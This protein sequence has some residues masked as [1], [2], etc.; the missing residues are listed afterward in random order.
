L[1]GTTRFA[2]ASIANSPG[3]VEVGELH[4]ARTAFDRARD[5][6]AQEIGR[7]PEHRRHRA[8]RLRRSTVHRQPALVHQRERGLERQRAGERERAELAE[9]VS[10]AHDGIER[11][12]DRFR[13]R[14]VRD[15]DRGLRVARL[16]E[17]L[18]RAVLAHRAQ[19]VPENRLRRGERLRGRGIRAR[20]VDAHRDDLRTLPGKDHA[21]AH[22]SRRPCRSSKL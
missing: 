14:D 21:D 3:R 6:G 7:E 16:R 2:P 11:V 18:L 15:E 5:R 22:V 1:S 20:G 19:I 9:R 4:A 12:A 13:E 8:V 17:L 10:G